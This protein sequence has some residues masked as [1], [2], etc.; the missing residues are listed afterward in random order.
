MGGDSQKNAPAPGAQRPGGSFKLISTLQRQP[1][2][3]QPSAEGHH[4]R[5]HGAAPAVLGKRE[6]DHSHTAIRPIKPASPHRHQQQIADQLPAVFT[7]RQMQDAGQVQRFCPETGIAPVTVQKDPKR[8]AKQHGCVKTL[9]GLRS[10]SLRHS[11]SVSIITS[12]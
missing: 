5:Q 11:G 8:Q 7:Q 12:S 6:T 3:P 1:N 4:R 10:D 2:G 9:S